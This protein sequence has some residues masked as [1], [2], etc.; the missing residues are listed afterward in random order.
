MQDEFVMKQVVS[1]WHNSKEE[2]VAEA[3]QGQQEEDAGHGQG[4]HVPQEA[5]MAVIHINDNSGSRD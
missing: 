4:E 3:G 2:V 5:F 1:R